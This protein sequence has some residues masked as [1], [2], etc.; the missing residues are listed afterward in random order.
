MTD[1]PLILHLEDSPLDAELVESEL[2]QAFPDVRCLKVDSESAFREALAN[3]NVDLVLADMSLSGYDGNSALNFVIQNY[4]HIPFIFVSGTMGEYKAI[5]SLHNGAIDYV[6]K[7]KLSRLVPAVKRALDEAGARRKTLE[8]ERERERNLKRL[9]LLIEVS[10]FQATTVAELLD[11]ALERILLLTDSAI[12]YIYHYS[13]NTREFTLNAWSKQVMTECGIVEPQTVYQL[14]KTG[15]WG[16]VVRRRRAIIVNDFAAPNPLKRGWPEGHVHISRFMSIPVV[17][18]GQ[19]VAVVGVGNKQEPY[20][21]S[22]QLQLELMSQEVWRTVQRI[23]LKEEIINGARQWQET[24]DA[25]SDSVCLMDSER[26]IIRSNRATDENFGSSCDGKE[27]LECWKY[28][29]DSQE[30]PHDC[31]HEKARI[32]RR[33]ESALIQNGD[34]WFEFSLDP[35][36]DSSNEFAGGVHIVRDVTEMLSLQ[37]E[38]FNINALFRLFM[39]CSPI[40]S[41]VKKVSEACS[42]VV[43]ASDNMFELTG[44]SAADMIGKTMDE[45]FTAEFARKITADDQEVMRTRQVL[46]IE[47][48]YRGGSYITYKFPI[49]LD[50]HEL[51]LAGYTVD[52]TPIKDAEK[53][54]R[55]MQVQMF[56]HEKLASIGHLAAGIAHEINNPMGFIVSN[57]ATMQRYIEKFDSYLQHLEQRLLVDGSL[58]EDISAM[59]RSLK[60]DY[61]SGDIRNLLR[62]CNDGTARVMKI[63]SDLKTFSRSDSG[64][65]DYADLNECLNSTIN[66]VWNEIKYVA[67]LTRDLGELPPLRCNAQQLNQVF[68]NLLVNAAHAIEESGRE[69][70]KIVVTTRKAAEQVIIAIA[71]NGCGIPP[72]IRSHIFDAFFTTKEIGKGTG[73]GLSISSQIV[74]KHRGTL[75]MESA[76]GFGSTFVVKLPLEIPAPVDNRGEAG[77][78]YGLF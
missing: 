37:H 65:M 55:E 76:V 6:L 34:R 25:I 4:P 64:G 15:I 17:L 30:P 77:T 16:E 21:D 66:I 43:V 26:R 52:I 57:L 41:Y 13:E 24:F 42:R 5:D 54:M 2:R 22:D 58:P 56:H 7:V 11:Y 14:D 3:R 23:A 69:R 44:I 39:R 1:A 51:F 49:E 78:D 32:S 53:A 60:F 12:G 61:V 73:L 19:I 28:F 31:P 8:H 62:D 59:R 35:I 75:T 9:Q 38:F 63:V 20:D 50:N 18:D 70:G 45:L 10:Q 71:D 72:E 74:H 27:P 33:R 68:L 48:E 29:H 40:Y 46:R 36:I 47:E 67:D